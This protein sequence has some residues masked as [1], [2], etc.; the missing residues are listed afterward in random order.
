MEDTHKAVQ[1]S[2]MTSPNCVS[3]LGGNDGIFKVKGKWEILLFPSLLTKRL[4]LGFAQGLCKK[5][6]LLPCHSSSLSGLV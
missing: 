1:G 5:S 6:E 3:T 2:G 4:Y